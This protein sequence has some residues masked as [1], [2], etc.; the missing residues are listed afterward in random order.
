MRD[1][2]WLSAPFLGFAW[3]EQVRK[4]FDGENALF[5]IL[6][7]YAC[8]DAVEQ[9]EVI[10]LLSLCVARPLKG[11]ERTMLVQHNGRGFMRGTRCPCL[12]G[13][14]ERHEV[15]STLAQGDGMG[16]AVHRNKSSSHGRRVLE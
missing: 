15:G 6:P 3:L 12:N 11:T 7:L 13:F 5:L 2:G 16:G 10:L 4:L 9:G 14:K 1:W 8:R